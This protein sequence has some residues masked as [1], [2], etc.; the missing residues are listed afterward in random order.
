MD[1]SEQNVNKDTYRTSYLANK[2]N[3]FEFFTENGII[4]L[5]CIQNILYKTNNDENL[6]N[7]V[8]FV[9]TIFTLKDSKLAYEKVEVVK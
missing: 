9:N 6:V 4:K 1:F 2:I 3:K 5:K 7:N 8:G